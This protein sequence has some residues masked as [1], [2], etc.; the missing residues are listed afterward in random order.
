[1]PKQK[2][3]NRAVSVS[4]LV[5][6]KYKV[7]PF[8]GAWLESFG[9]PERSGS[10]IIWGNSGNGKTRF[11]LQLAKYL[12]QF[13][14]VAYNSLEEG[15]SLSLKKAVIETG[16]LEVKNR[17]VILDKEPIEELEKRLEKHKS[18]NIIFIDSLQYTGFTKMKYKEFTNKFHNKLF[19][20]ISHAEGKNPE[21]RLGKAVRFDAHLKLRVEGYKIPAPE[22]RY[23]GKE[24]FIIWPE[25][26]AEY[27]GEI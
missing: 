8:T 18:P 12:A 20:F 7:L 16:L 19:I 1:M 24:P 2:A 13:E 15:V 9:E 17:F 5:A 22:G 25:G 27:W 11:A 10:W 3:I 23:G 14:K 6:R 21:G 26:A 4:E